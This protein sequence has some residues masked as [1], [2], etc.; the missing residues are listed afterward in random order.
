MRIYKMNWFVKMIT[1]NWPNAITLAPFGIFIKEKYY[2]NRIFVTHET[3]H[4]K[5]QMEMLIIPFYLWYLIE[6]LIKLFIYGSRAYMSI[7]FERE[8]YSN[9]NDFK[10]LSHRKRFS[11][12]KRVFK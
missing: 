6:W 3:I 5:Q 7:S 1:L 9:D 11:W 2:Y 10:Y 12:I 8:A 4:W